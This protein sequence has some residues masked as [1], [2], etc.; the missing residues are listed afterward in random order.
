[1]ESKVLSH[2]HY[3]RFD[4]DAPNPAPAKVVS[5]SALTCPHFLGFS[6]CNLSSLIC[7][8]FYACSLPKPTF[9]FKSSLLGY[10]QT[11]YVTLSKY[12]CSQWDQME[13]PNL[14]C[15]NPESFR[16]MVFLLHR[17]WGLRFTPSDHDFLHQSHVFSNISKIL[18]RSEEVLGAGEEGVASMYESHGP[19]SPWGL[20]LV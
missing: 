17:C 10:L 18:S 6:L 2:F 8:L 5:L 12:F 3:S 7:Y 4:I 1:M 20:A 11:F 9:Y 19:V 13:E 15:F 14:P 16:L